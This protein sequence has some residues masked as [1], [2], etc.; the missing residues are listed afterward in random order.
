M[1][2]NNKLV[3]K[4]LAIFN[5]QFSTQA[6]L[7]LIELLT[8]ISVMAIISTFSLASF[9]SYNNSQTLQTSTA[10]VVTLLTLAKSRAI[11]QIVD[12]QCSNESLSGYQVVF[13]L[14]DQYAL[15]VVC[16]GTIYEV[17]TTQ[18]LAKNLTFKSIDAAHVMFNAGTGIVTEQDI[19]VIT[20]YGNTKTITIST[21]GV[22]S[23]K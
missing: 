2:V 14:P 17:G 19:I 20:G 10:D 13:T 6:G 8:T 11:S 4:K 7:T 23:V 12:R 5:Y 16:D 1:K 21:T 3:M 9:A 22:I 15:Q 18:T